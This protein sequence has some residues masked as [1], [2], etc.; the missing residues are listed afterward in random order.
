MI[1]WHEGLFLQPHHLQSLQRGVYKAA[2]GERRFSMAFPYGVIEAR[3]AV[4]D[5]EDHR[6]RFDR[7]HVALPSGAVF[8]FPEDAELPSLDIK[9]AFRERG[10]DFM[11][12]LAVPVWLAERPNT[13][14]YGAA[15]A[16]VRQKIIYRVAESEVADENTGRNK[17]PLQV[18][19][20]NGM[21]M[22]DD[23]DFS[24]TEYIPLLRVMRQVS[25]GAAGLPR[26][27]PRYVPPTLL[28]RAAP[29]LVQL[30]RDLTS[31]IAATRDQLA[32]HLAN[33]PLDLRSLQGMQFE[34]LAR[35][36]CLHRSAGQL[37][38]LIDTAEGRV[39]PLEVYLELRSLLNE[40]EALYP[41]RADWNCAAYNH[42]DPW[43]C[44]EELDAKI[45]SYLG[46][47][48]KPRYRKVEFRF[49]DG[50]FIGDIEPGFFPDAT[51]FFLCVETATDPAQLVRLMEDSDHF[52]LMPAS[53][54]PRAIR[55]L[56]LKE[57]RHP[58][59][60]LPVKART[61]YYRLNRDASSSCASRRR[62]FTLNR[63]TARSLPSP[64]TPRW[65]RRW[66][67]PL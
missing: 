29:P 51:G 33:T 14:E 39:P 41:S 36:R 38:T 10:D 34:Q 19:R 61:Y 13:I 6:I 28:L 43:P 66:A 7:L 30:V 4:D 55:G 5:L 64:S 67:D 24:D 25:D 37:F 1:H 35:L 26:M 47:V 16:G 17:Q 2:Y 58:P 45:R 56:A 32:A 63:R 27:N 59:F 46:G 48:V 21:L 8:R 23:E 11:I 50:Y 18:R 53:F 40:L 57:E 31:Q 60:E 62:S 54:G 65:L 12:Y 9:A 15:Q 3:L 42:D 20:L 49:Q 44:F 52:K 22:F